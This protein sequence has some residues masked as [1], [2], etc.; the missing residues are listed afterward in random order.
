MMPG[1]GLTSIGLAGVVISYSG[2]A[3]TFIDGMHA[4]TG[5]TMFFGLIFLAAGILDGGVSTSNRAKATTLV[6]ISITLSFAAF[7]FTLNTIDSTNIF[8]GIMMVMITPAIVI[9]YISAKMPQYT[10]PIGSIFILAAGAGIITFVAFGMI[11]PDTY[12][13]AEPEEET[14]MVEEETM[15]VPVDKILTIR[16]LEGSIER[17]NPDYDPDES[18]VPQGHVIEWINE[19]TV[20]HTATSFADL[21]DT[22][23]TGLLN[24]GDTYLLDTSEI[25]IGEYEYHCSI[26]P[27]MKSVLTIE[28]AEEETEAERV[29]VLMPD[30]AGIEKEGQLY[31]DPDVITIP[32]GTIVT[33][34]NDDSAI[35]TVTSQGD[36]ELEFDSGI[37]NAGDVF[38][39]QFT[40]KGEFE[41]ICIVHPFMKGMVIVE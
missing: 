37:M 14:E 26:H 10:R 5:L 21:G 8:A 34:T 18:I 33:W 25:P 2:L 39:Y 3:H 38:E 19:D 32:V 1:M 28:E 15:T 35:H 9:A 31:Y 24:L 16:M 41:Y 7:G 17:G 30:G 4:L 36:G 12:L 22:F 6:V 40:D 27:W 20:Q 13:I 29:D 11:G 23:D